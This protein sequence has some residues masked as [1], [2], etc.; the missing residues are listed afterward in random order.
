MTLQL[1]LTPYKVLLVDDEENITRSITRLLM[2][3]E[4]ELEVFSATSGS[5]GIELL[6]RQPDMAVIV[7][8]QRMPEMTGAQFLEQARLVAPD[9]VRMV[10]TGYADMSATLEAINRG[11]T[12]RY[13]TKPWE[14]GI[15]CRNI[16]EGV[17]QY[18]LVQENR[19]LTALVAQQNRELSEW[20]D[21]LKSRVL[22]QTATIRRQNEE[23]RGKNRRIG[24]SFSS[25]I[26]AFS[27]LIEL[28]SC[29]LQDHTRNV[30]ALSTAC[31]E[32]LGLDAEQTATVRT[33]ALLHDIGMIGIPPALLDKRPLEM[34]QEETD[35]YQQ[36]AVRGQAAL[37]AVDDLREAALL[38][39]HHHER[40]DGQ[41]FPDRVAGK[42]IP[43]GAR[44]IAFADFIDL[45]L[46]GTREQDGVEAVLALAGKQLGSRLDPALFDPMLRH[47][48]AL[49]ASLARSAPPFVENE[50]RPRELHEGQ[51]ISRNLYSG[52]GLL[53][54]TK[55]TEL[56]AAKIA[57]IVRYYQ[58]DP[59]D[60]GVWVT[61]G[62]P[63][64]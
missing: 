42:A 36:H 47:A 54:L 28:Q 53:L 63:A 21:S 32:E 59:P 22:E 10:L 25:T 50:L 64:P 40:Y 19:A 27:R 6:K 31:A 3:L 16:L 62:A 20:N 39:R 7:S 58:I 30:T 1:G 34:T 29:K 33:A 60:E 23:L 12:W 9:A 38:I 56:D 2:D 15:L 4:V 49:Y 13:L 46:G 8:D 51:T 18:R 24:Q 37:D 52:T 5:E 57:S 48:T 45:E 41:G 11:G 26:V 14:D 44:I 43:L 35:L 17:E 55:G 61:R